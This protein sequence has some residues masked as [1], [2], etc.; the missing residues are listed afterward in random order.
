M[1]LLRIAA[2]LS[3]GALQDHLGSEA[4]G[5]VP[6]TPRRR[7]QSP[8]PCVGQAPLSSGRLLKLYSSLCKECTWALRRT[9]R[10][11]TPGSK[12]FTS[13][14]CCSRKPWPVP[15]LS[16]DDSRERAFST[17]PACALSHER[18]V[19]APR[20]C[21]VPPFSRTWEETGSGSCDCSAQGAKPRV[22]P[23]RNALSCSVE[24][25]AE[26][27]HRCPLRLLTRQMDVMP[28]EARKP[29]SVTACRPAWVSSDVSENW[30]KTADAAGS[31]ALPSLAST[32]SP[33]SRAAL[34]KVPNA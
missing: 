22:R 15:K 18:T 2:N 26:M 27:I 29:Q 3:K 7:R 24:T 25:T 32:L 13:F 6:G 4:V 19:P 30:Q 11:C 12:P 14:F 5:V 9:F 31:R 10:E 21:P 23:C 17:V 34:M 1:T 20:L 28:L 16:A 8:D 33:E